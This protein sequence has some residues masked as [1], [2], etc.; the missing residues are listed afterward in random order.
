MIDLCKN[1]T[2]TNIFIYIIYIILHYT[3]SYIIF[4]EIP[5]PSPIFFLLKHHEIGLVSV[6]VEL[7]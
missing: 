4:L 2:E 7:K 1:K 6:E 3:D 5:V